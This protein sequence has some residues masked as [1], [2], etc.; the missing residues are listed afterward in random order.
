M[1]LALATA[2][3][4]LTGIETT[5]NF[6]LKGQ[7]QLVWS[8]IVSIPCLLLALLALVL[9]RRRHFKNEMRKRLHL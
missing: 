6:Y 5:V 3:L 4:L 7:F 1:A 8:L 2:P 9:D